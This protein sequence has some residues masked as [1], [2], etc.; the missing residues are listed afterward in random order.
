MIEPVALGQS[1]FH[2]PGLAADE[3]GVAMGRR[4]L[5]IFP[6]MPSTVGFFRTISR[7]GALKELLPSLTLEEAVGQGGLREVAVGFEVAGSYA[8]DP[9]AAAARAHK[10]LVFT[11]TLRHYVPYRDSARPLGCDVAE[12]GAVLPGEG[13]Y[14]LYLEGGADS[15]APGRKV[16]FRDLLMTLA[17]VALRPKE[18]REQRLDQVI[19]R[20]P[21]GLLTAVR[22]YLW[23][24]RVPSEIAMVRPVQQGLFGAQRSELALVRAQELPQGVLGLMDGT[25]GLEVYVPATDNVL[26]QRGFR[27]PM[28]LDSCAALFPRDEM[29]LFAAARRVVE[30]LAGPLHWVPLDDVTDVVL[31]N[32]DNA[33]V[34]QARALEAQQIERLGVAVR[35]VPDRDARGTAEAV[36]LPAEKLPEL[37]AL[38]HL[39]PSVL[40][41]GC[42]V[43]LAHP[44]TVI[45]SPEGV[46]ALP[47]GQ[48]LMQVHPRVYI[49]VGH[50]F[51]PRLSDELALE[52][53]GLAG[54]DNLV[55]HPPSGP[56]FAVSRSAFQPLSR[57]SVH[58][59]DLTASLQAVEILPGLEPV[60]TPVVHH[61]VGG[62]LKRW[63][64][65]APAQNPPASW[66]AERDDE[67]G[68][69]ADATGKDEGV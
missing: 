60:G 11:G 52:H 35:M 67:K 46:R 39:L 23:R 15:R 9:C 63:N 40:W 50:R 6:D 54:N 36:V 68:E 21:R 49:P 44:Y 16:E 41:F 37:L 66:P 30:R 10:G 5:A 43:A 57:A 7:T 59:E 33:P 32:Q 27:H 34:P 69:L 62:Q 51:S 17:P 14:V 47:V 22:S 61:P 29:T 65:M 45:L 13:G 19:L 24:R 20:V 38:V 55:F 42:E 64:G 28:A 3:R 53:F 8:A 31:T 25:P 48:A 2:L 4:L 26:V 12:P 18:L 56:P 58:T 1:R